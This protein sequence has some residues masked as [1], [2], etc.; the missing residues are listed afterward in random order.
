MDLELARQYITKAAES[1]VAEFQFD[2]GTLYDN[3]ENSL[4]DPV[5]AAYW[6]ELAAAQGLIDAEATL[7]SMKL[8]GRGLEKDLASARQLLLSAAK[9]GHAV[10]QNNLGLMYVRGVGTEQDYAAALYWFRE[11]VEQSHPQATTNLAVMYENGFGV[12]FD[13]Q[14]AKRLYQLAGQQ[15]A[16]NL[17]SL[18]ALIEFEF[19]ERLKSFDEGVDGVELER[20]ANTGDPVAQYQYGWFLT[21]LNSTSDYATAGGYYMK[22]ARSGL[23]SA[24]LNLGILYLKGFGVP[25][26]FIQGYHWINTAASKNSAA[27]MRIRNQLLPFLT[28]QQLDQAQGESSGRAQ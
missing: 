23:P 7:G 22:S 8:E 19:D 15:T 12:P 13:E 11:A 20:S 27:A 16:V 18:V 28:P 14:E 4:Y 3:P 10:A 1:G 17:A 26:D 24:M 9:A 2:A 21:E 6:Y 25:Q 5:Q